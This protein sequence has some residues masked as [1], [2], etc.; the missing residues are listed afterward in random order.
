MKRIM[1][2]HKYYLGKCDYNHSGRKTCPAYITWTLDDGKFSMSAE[3]WNHIKS[4]IYRCGQCVDTVAGYFKGN[5]KA[6]RMV[7][8]WKRYSAQPWGSKHRH[9]NDLTTGS[10]DQEKW[11][12]DNPIPQEEYA[13][14]ASRYTV[15]SN[16]LAD[17]GLN[18]D[19]NYT[20]NKEPY[21]YG[22]A[23]LN[24]A[25]PAEIIAEIQSWD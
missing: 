3:I 9:L 5:K 11:L 20:H 10:P 15:A 6:R 21:N 23:W 17:A 8:V 24:T 1:D 19:P 18:P 16:K 25:I 2:D 14:P 7:E 4:D 22:A 13:Y 12:Q